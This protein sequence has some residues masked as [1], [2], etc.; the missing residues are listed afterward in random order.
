M[1]LCLFYRAGQVH[2]VQRAGVLVTP[3]PREGERHH[4][5]LL[6]LVQEVQES[7]PHRSVLEEQK[8]QKNKEQDENMKQEAAVRD[9][10]KSSEV[11]EEKGKGIT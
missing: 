1:D 9:K 10:Y 5:H 4:R 2:G 3:R 8:T 6:P 11:T 7:E